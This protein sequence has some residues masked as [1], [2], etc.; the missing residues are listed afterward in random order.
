MSLHLFCLCSC[1]LPSPGFVLIGRYLVQLL[2][3]PAGRRSLQELLWY[4]PVEH[5]L[6]PAERQV[7]SRLL[8]QPRHQWRPYGSRTDTHHSFTRAQ[9]TKRPIYRLQFAGARDAHMASN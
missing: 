7:G 3:V 5:H 6:G 1:A 2:L 9:N 8:P 4:Y